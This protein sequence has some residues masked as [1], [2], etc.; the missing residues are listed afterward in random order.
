LEL[1]GNVW[2]FPR[3]RG[4]RSELSSPLSLSLFEAFTLSLL[5]SSHHYGILVCDVGLPG[6]RLGSC[7][8]K[9]DLFLGDEKII[10]SKGIFRRDDTTV[11]GFFGEENCAKTTI[12]PRGGIIVPG[13]TEFGVPDRHG[14]ERGSV[15]A[16]KFFIELKVL[17]DLAH[18]DRSMD[19][20]FEI[21]Y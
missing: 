12:V 16:S 13:T 3:T 20:V 14:S 5:S 1:F 18:M 19:R 8:P 10:E 7:R 11:L 9:T 2:L 15:A 6:N 4:W 21:A 17:G